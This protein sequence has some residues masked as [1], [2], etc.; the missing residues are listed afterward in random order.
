MHNLSESDANRL[1]TRL[2]D[3]S[4]EAQKE[5]QPDG[6]WSISTDSADAL[7]ALK[8]LDDVRF[9]RR[10]S[11]AEESGDSVLASPEERRARTSRL[12]SREIEASVRSIDGVLEA[13]V[14]LNIPSP[15]PLFGSTAG[16]K[17]GSASV[18]VTVAPGAQVLA[19]DLQTLVS[20]A[21]GIASKDIGV[22][23]SPGSLSPQLEPHSGLL[24]N[25]HISA[26]ARSETSWRR[27]ILL[28]I[29]LTLVAL[30][31][32]VLFMLK[33]LKPVVEGVRQA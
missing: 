26:E 21:T 7:R 25:L 17:K 20:G 11:I 29:G 27:E 28:Y 8:Y 5:K 18:V 1:L 24:S 3:V 6:N 4:I 30:A 32:S 10:D 23:I 22:L 2:H 9:F 16:E 19:A 33:R 14:H 31:V 13:H 12:L 15:D